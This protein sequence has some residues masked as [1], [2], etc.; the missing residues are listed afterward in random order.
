MALAKKG[1]ESGGPAPGSFSS[2]ARRLND[3]VVLCGDPST[4]VASSGRR[5]HESVGAQI[6]YLWV[7]SGT[8]IKGREPNQ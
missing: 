3:Q 2:V 8:W 6:P 5:S 7:R 1:R 4:R